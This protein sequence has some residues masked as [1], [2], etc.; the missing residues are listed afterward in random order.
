[1][2]AD[3]DEPSAFFNFSGV[4]SFTGLAASAASSLAAEAAS[5]AGCFV[6]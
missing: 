3:G 2:K 4:E 1:M 6:D 5:P